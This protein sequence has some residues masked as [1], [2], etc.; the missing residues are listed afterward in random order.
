MSGKGGTISAITPKSPA[1][2]PTEQGLSGVHNCSTYI[3]EADVPTFCP[4]AGNFLEEKVGY[5]QLIL[6]AF[7][8]A[9]EGLPDV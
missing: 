7:G 8:W 1:A 4:L 5:S 6:M 9:K 2:S 3:I